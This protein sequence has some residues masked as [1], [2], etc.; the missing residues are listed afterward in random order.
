M[1]TDPQPPVLLITKSQLAREL[2]CS[3]RHLQRL[4]ARRVIPFIRVSPKCVRFRR[5]AV[6]AALVRREVDPGAP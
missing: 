6:L 1:P 4:M 5:E 3:E 2:Q